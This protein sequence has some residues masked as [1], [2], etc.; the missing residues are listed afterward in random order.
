MVPT[1]EARGNG[2][3]RSNQGVPTC[4]RRLAALR[5]QLSLAQASSTP[6]QKKRVILAGIFHETHS[7]VDEVTSLSDFEV[8]VGDA[9]LAHRGD[10]SPLAGALEVADCCG[11]DLR[12]VIDLR[13]TPS[14]LCADEV[15]EFFWRHLEAAVVAEEQID[16]VYLVLHGAMCSVSHP[17]TEAE[18]VRRLRTALVD[19]VP[20]CGVLDM[21]GNISEEMIR[22][23]DGL[24]AYRENPHI[25]AK[26]AS[27]RGAELLDRIMASGQRPRC[28]YRQ[29]PV[30]WPPTGV[31]TADEPMLTLE[32]MARQCEARH[33]TTVAHCSVMGGFGY[34]DCDSTGVSFHCATFGDDGDTRVVEVEL[35]GMASHA[36]RHRATGNV[37]EPSLASVLPQMTEALVKPGRKGPVLLIEPSDNIG[38]GAPGDATTL[39][40]HLLE[41]DAEEEGWSDAAVCIDDAA[42]VTSLAGV[43]VGST[44]SISVGGRGSS[45]SDPPLTELAVELLSLTDGEFDLE[46][47]N[48]HLASMVGLH[49]SMGP[50]AL[51]RCVAQP[52]VR[53]LLTSNKTAPFDLGQLRS[54]GI[55]PE[56]CDLICVKA[57]V[58]HRAAYDPIA[59]ASFWVS[60]PGPCASDLTTM[61]YQHA[62]R[63]LYPLDSIQ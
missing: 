57:A 48:S 24:V 3:Q 18:I 9:M 43:A 14:G 30:V 36:L 56:E 53:V 59:A 54:Q 23:T 13:A 52:G 19:T 60:T 11:W 16:G 20:I 42:A 17:D 29:V 7:F 45:I 28:I 40:R 51:V 5:G 26:D 12:P 21:H 39:L 31:G 37:V 32:A 25:D 33:P 4:T 22:Q 46:N 62:R 61:P 41:A 10:A 34:G 35:D 63:P 49:I 27:K 1:A 15:L 50:S 44:A 6:P 47:P 8:E 55:V 58:A 2:Q 38:G